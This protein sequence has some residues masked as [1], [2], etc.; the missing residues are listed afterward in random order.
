VFKFLDL[1]GRFS[2]RNMPSYKFR[3]SQHLDH[4]SA[5]KA[6]VSKQNFTVCPR[7]WYVD[8]TL[9]CARC[10]NVFHFGV[11]EQRVWY[12]EYKFWTDSFP[13]RCVECRRDL[14]HLT[15][16][17]KEYDRDIESVM[18]GDDCAAKERIAIVIDT[19]CEMDGTLPQKIHENRKILAKQIAKRRGTNDA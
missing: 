9:K 3:G 6:D 18:R 15:E 11:D 7:F 13:N 17:R 4:K 1:F 14:R 8:A 12:E 5:V 10:G 2:S 19:M 16:L